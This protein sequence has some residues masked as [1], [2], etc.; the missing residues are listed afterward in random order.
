RQLF[1]AVTGVVVRDDPATHDYPLAMEAEGRDEIFVG[2]IRQDTSLPG[3]RG[4]A[5]WIVADNLRVGAAT[6]AVQLAEALVA[7]D[8][9]LPRSR[10]AT[11]GH[12]AAHVASAAAAR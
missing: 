12:G 6:N 5:L 8:W 7:R 10:R 11:T 2:R 9:V 4:L 3:N 1:A